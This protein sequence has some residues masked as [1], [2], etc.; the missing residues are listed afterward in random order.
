MKRFAQYIRLSTGPQERG[1]GAEKQARVNTEYVER[2]GGQLVATYRDTITGKIKTRQ[3]LDA[4][5]ADAGRGLFDAAVIYDVKR[6]GRL[7]LPIL[8]IG[9][10]IIGVGLELH[11]SNSSRQIDLS[12]PSDRLLFQIEAIGAEQ[13]YFY[14]V[15]RLYDDRISAA[16]K[17]RFVGYPLVY[18]LRRRFTPTGERVIEYDPERQEW[19]LKIFTWAAQGLGCDRIAARLTA[20]GAPLPGRAGYWRPNT[21]LVMLRNRAYTGQTEVVFRRK[22]GGPLGVVQQLPPLVPVELFEQVQ[23]RLDNAPKSGP[24]HSRLAEFPLVGML[25]CGGC[26]WSLSV[27]R[28]TERGWTRCRNRHCK[29]RVHFKYREIEAA[30]LAGARDAVQRGIVALPPFPV[31]PADP[32]PNP[33]KLQPLLERED[34]IKAMTEAGMYTLEEGRARLEAVRREMA[35]LEATVAASAPPALVA[36][37]LPKHVTPEALRRAGVVFVIHRGK[38]IEMRR[39]VVT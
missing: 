3:G 35:Q 17:G 33:A 4:L 20:E 10:E 26:G 23:M 22:K 11:F 5:L 9:E 12:D 36:V 34:R 7:V 13:D 14:T 39:R 15:S 8:Q 27:N 29:E 28:Y 21:V 38:R 30:C 6:Q 16:L 31:I 2:Q 37:E 18:G 19:P 1:V 32:T 25:R 24:R